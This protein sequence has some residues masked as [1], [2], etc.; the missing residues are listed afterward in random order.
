M[1]NIEEKQNNISDLSSLD[2]SDA[3][4]EILEEKI[5]IIKEIFKETK[6]AVYIKNPLLLDY[7]YINDITFVV[8]IYGEFLS[9]GNIKLNDKD[10]AKITNPIEIIG[11]YELVEKLVSLDFEYFDIQMTL[12]LYSSYPLAS[13]TPE[14]Y[15]PLKAESFD[16]TFMALQVLREKLV[17]YINEEGN[18]ASRNV[19]KEGERSNVL[20]LLRLIYIYELV[21]KKEFS[22]MSILDFKEFITKNYNELY[23][24]AIARS[25]TKNN[26][27][28]RDMY[29][30][31]LIL[32]IK[33]SLWDRLMQTNHLGLVTKYYPGEDNT[34]ERF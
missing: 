5:S 30:R 8:S 27:R 14:Q 13:L 15:S 6:I 21:D 7:Q 11:H 4:I 19:S 18:F 28:G 26:Y 24:I 32:A 17:E 22:K 33:N 12:P 29:L 9:L 3:F 1:N 23:A 34:F 31:E 20:N 16:F 25:N 10:Q 2:L